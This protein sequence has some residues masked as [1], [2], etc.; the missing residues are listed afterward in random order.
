MKNP[1]LSYREWPAVA[2]VDAIRHFNW[3]G[4]GRGSFEDLRCAVAELEAIQ[5]ALEVRSD[6]RELLATRFR[7]VRVEVE[8]ARKLAREC[9]LYGPV[10][11][12]VGS[13]PVAFGDVFDA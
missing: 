11:G 12:T 5:R 13:P 6:V 3:L 7:G 8:A 4:A 1:Y 2:V 9:G 10:G